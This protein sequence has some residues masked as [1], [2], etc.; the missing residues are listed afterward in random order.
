MNEKPGRTYELH[1][2]RSILWMMRMLRKSLHMKTNNIIA[3][4]LIEDSR[5]DLDSIRH[6]SICLDIAEDEYKYL[7]SK[8]SSE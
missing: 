3:K 7:S 4:S 1:L 6:I 2:D 5:M 8:Q